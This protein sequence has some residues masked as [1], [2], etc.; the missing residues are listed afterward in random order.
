MNQ[1]VAREQKV[2]NVFEL[3]GIQNQLHNLLEGNEKKLES[4]KTKILKIS[5]SYSLGKCSPE[6]IVNCGL[7]AL[8]LNLP[9]EAGQGYIVNY[10]GKACFDS[11]YKG[12]QILAKRAGF[13]VLADVV[14][15]CDTYSQSGIG[16]TRQI[17]YE[18]NLK[19]RHGSNDEWAKENL[20]G[21][22]VSILDTQINV[23]THH[24]ISSEM[25]FKII[26]ESPS[27]G[28]VSRKTG[29]KHSPHDNWAEQMFCAKA[30]KQ[31]LTKFAIDLD[32]A[33]ELKNAIEI[34]N[35]TEIEA[36]KLIPKSRDYP[37][38]KLNKFFP[39]WVKLINS[40]KQTSDSIISLISNSYDLTE[41]QLEKLGELRVV[42]S[43]VIDQESIE[44]ETENVE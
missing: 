17:T 12:W 20:S 24:F 1:L 35:N 16:H 6:S 4:F 18:P 37:D 39:E 36:Q 26:G 32:E 22:I 42:E 30:I 19:E 15:K 23:E 21:V 40:G 8:T 41:E 10:G 44:Q 11:G 5:L 2:M 29:K 38:E 3:E 28:K 14:Y 13:S 31:V 43:N 34:I 33:T 9:L 7:Q 25:I 27:A